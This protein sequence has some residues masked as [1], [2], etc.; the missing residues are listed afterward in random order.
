MEKHEGVGRIRNVTF[1]GSCLG[2]FAFMVA[3]YLFACVLGGML[4]VICGQFSD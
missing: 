3:L 1:T 2:A 4:V